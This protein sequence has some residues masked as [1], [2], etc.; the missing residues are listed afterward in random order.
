MA[1]PL[2]IINSMKLKRR[3]G[4]AL[5]FVFLVGFASTVASVLRWVF[6]FRAYR[7]VQDNAGAVYKIEIIKVWTTAEVSTAS[8]AFCLPVLRSLVRKKWFKKKSRHWA[9]STVQNY[10]EKRRRKAAERKGDSGVDASATGFRDEEVG[11]I[12]AQE[13]EMVGM[14]R[15]QEEG[16]VTVHMSEG[17]QESEQPLEGGIRKFGKKAATY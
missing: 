4:F 13:V 1:L 8:I 16:R 15:A 7:L 14:E 3:E 5:M 17:G 2:F 12:W 10:M 6:I 9:G 11:G